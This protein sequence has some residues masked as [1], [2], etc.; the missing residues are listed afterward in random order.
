MTYSD[1]VIKKINK[2][3]ADETITGYRIERD[4]GVSAPITSRL[5]SGTLKVENMKFKTVMALLE[6]YTEIERQ[7]KRELIDSEEDN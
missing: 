7:R 4:T 3:M 2:L 5:R 6:Y 1:R